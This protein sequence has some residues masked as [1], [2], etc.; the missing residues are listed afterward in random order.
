MF[1]N[2]WTMSSNIDNS[3]RSI[4]NK[5]W[6]VYI[7]DEEINEHSH[8]QRRSDFQPDFCICFIVD[9]L[10]QHKGGLCKFNHEEVGEH[11]KRTTQHSYTFKFHES[12]NHL[13]LVARKHNE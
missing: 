6:K 3:T 10:M 13:A 7:Y 4:V 2:D 5:S 1:T 9:M 8:N 12:P 11:E